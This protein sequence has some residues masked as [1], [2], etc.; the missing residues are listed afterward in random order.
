MA[1]G[2][3][4]DVGTENINADG[5]TYV[6]LANGTWELKHRILAVE[7]LGRK[8]TAGERVYFLDGDRNNLVVENI[9]IARKGSSSIAKRIEILRARIQDSLDELNDLLAD[10]TKKDKAST[11]AGTP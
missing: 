10:E 9:G 7:K 3:K 5:Y 4:V 8:L 2:S 6:K 11:R 1:R